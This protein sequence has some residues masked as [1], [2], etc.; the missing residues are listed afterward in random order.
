MMNVTQLFGAYM[1]VTGRIFGEYLVE[2]KQEIIK[3][4]EKKITSKRKVKDIEFGDV[5]Q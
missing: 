5:H 1:I 3:N 2:R 4:E